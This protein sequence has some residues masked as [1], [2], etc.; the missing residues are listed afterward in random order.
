MT[1]LVSVSDLQFLILM[2]PCATRREFTLVSGETVVLLGANGSGKT[3]FVL[4][5]NG[6][7]A[8][9]R[10]TD[11][12]LTL[13]DRTISE[14]SGD[15]DSVQDATISYSCLRYWTMSLGQGDECTGEAIKGRRQPS[16]IRNHSGFD[17]ARIT[18]AR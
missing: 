14:I 15:R 4:Q 18:S 2:D 5:L 9:G 1:P 17:R 12:G 13:T 7:Y 8:A 3:T 16:P 10:H 11:R 6:F